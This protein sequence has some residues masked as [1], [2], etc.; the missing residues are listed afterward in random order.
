MTTG[1]RIKRLREGLKLT[2]EQVGAHVGVNKATVQRYESGEID[3]KRNVAISLAEILQTTPAYLMGW[4]SIS[5]TFA[6]A[7]THRIPILGRVS[8]GLPMY[9]EQ[10]IEGY[11]YT[12]LNGGSEY[13][14]LRVHG[15]SMNAVNI[16][17]GCYVVVRRQSTADNGAIAIVSV[18][19]DEATIKRFRQEGNMVILTPH[20]INPEHQPQVYDTRKTRVEIIGIVVQVVIDKQFL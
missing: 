18:G 19:D 15:D 9:A 12:E 3:L 17:D 8:A 20:S 11:V 6:Y 14:G 7:P 2:L 4:E 10:N 16:V 5:D 1:Q 13:F